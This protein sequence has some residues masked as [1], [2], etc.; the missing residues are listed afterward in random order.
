[1]KRRLTEKTLHNLII[2]VYNGSAIS[3]V[4]ILQGYTNK[5]LTKLREQLE[6][7][8]VRNYAH[9]QIVMNLPGF[10]QEARYNKMYSW[11]ARPIISFDGIDKP[12]KFG[13]EIVYQ[14]GTILK[15]L[16]VAEIRNR[17]IQDLG[18]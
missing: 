13:E 9:A 12:A 16:I 3:K 18:L 6:G 11:R 8:E 4:D 2:E 14:A 15:N 7:P 5:Q 10:T 1:M 17:K